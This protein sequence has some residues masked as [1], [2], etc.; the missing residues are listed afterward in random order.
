M[1]KNRF[2]FYFYEP[3]HTTILLKIDVLEAFYRQN[4]GL[5][6]LTANNPPYSSSKLFSAK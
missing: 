6:K 5:A 4:T 1:E 3:T 2:W